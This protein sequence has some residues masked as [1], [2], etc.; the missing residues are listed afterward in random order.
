MDAQ[1]SGTRS[2]A[3]GFLV[4]AALLGMTIISTGI[5][6]VVKTRVSENAESAAQLGATT[7]KLEATTREMAAELR[8][9]RSVLLSSIDV[10]DTRLQIVKE[11][12]EHSALTPIQ[13]SDI[14]V[15]IAEAY[16]RD[17]KLSPSIVLGLIEQESSF[18][19]DAV[20]KLGAIG[21]CQVL[22]TTAYPY[23]RAMGYDADAS[24]LTDPVINTRVA[25]LYLGDLMRYFEGNSEQALSA[26]FWGPNTVV[27]FLAGE[28]TIA[29]GH[30]Y[31]AEVL[32]K[33]EAYSQ[34]GLGG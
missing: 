31:A 9:Q 12:T 13:T 26:Y 20:S 29:F 34:D 32:K 3:Y 8:L 23:L 30:E 14:A 21:L 18:K 10:Q 28:Q 16:H 11:L 4:L 6:A 1:E 7:A 25:L 33:S 15:Y 24:L 22:P 27:R 19:P 2:R 5:I 17:R